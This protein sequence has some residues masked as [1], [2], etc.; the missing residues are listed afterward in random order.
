MLIGINGKRL[1]CSSQIEHLAVDVQTN[2]VGLERTGDSLGT[3]GHLNRECTLCVGRVAVEQQRTC[4]TAKLAGIYLEVHALVG[5]RS[6]NGLCTGLLLQINQCSTD[7]SFLYLVVDDQFRLLL[8][9]TSYES[10]HG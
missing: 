2:L 7:S 10:Q 8:I 4:L 1:G 6:L 9:L 5:N 3:S